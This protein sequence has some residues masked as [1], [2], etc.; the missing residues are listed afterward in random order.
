MQHHSKGAFAVSFAILC[1]AGAAACT[2]KPNDLFDRSWPSY[3]VNDAASNPTVD[4]AS[5]DAGHPPPGDTDANQGGNAE[6]DAA[7]RDS[8]PPPAEDATPPEPRDAGSTVAEDAGGGTVIVDAQVVPDVH[9][10]VEIPPFVDAG[11]PVDAGMGTLECLSLHGI[12]FKGHCYFT[13]AAGAWDQNACDAQG[14][15]LAT[16]TAADEQAAAATVSPGQERWIGLRRRNGSPRDPTS[17]EWVTGEPLSY[18]NWANYG[19]T[20]EP[21]GTG[22]CVRLLTAGTWADN[23]CSERF[24]VLCEHE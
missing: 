6:P 20:R 13:V 22:D 10:D 1:G 23:D 19:S 16:L 4:A 18:D 15:H 21:N 8:G 14:A 2:N 7:P 24:P 12:V 17:F 11:K 3:P 5:V 9:V